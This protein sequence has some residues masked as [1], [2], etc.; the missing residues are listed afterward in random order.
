MTFSVFL[1][2]TQIWFRLK[3]LFRQQRGAKAGQ[4]LASG[5]NLPARASSFRGREKKITGWSFLALVALFDFC[6]R[7]LAAGR[8]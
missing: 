4:P 3:Y 8:P 1:S 7:P 2:L 6:R 5:V